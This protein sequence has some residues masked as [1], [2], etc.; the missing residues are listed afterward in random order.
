M[1][2]DA[3]TQSEPQGIEWGPP[4]WLPVARIEDDRSGF[5][6]GER[7]TPRHLD[8][9]VETF[10]PRVRRVRVLCGAHR[11]MPGHWAESYPPVGEVVEMDHD[12]LNLWFRV[13]P[14][15]DP[16]L[17]VSRIG[18]MIA[19]G[20][21]QM[22]IAYLSEDDEVEG[23]ARIW[24]LAMLSGGEPPGIPNMPSWA[25]AGFGLSDDELRAAMDRRDR[26]SPGVSLLDIVRVGDFIP[27]VSTNR[28]DAL[29]WRAA[30][31]RS[32]VTEDL[33]EDDQM[34]DEDIRKMTEG[35]VS[36]LGPVLES[37]RAAPEPEPEPAVEPEPVTTAAEDEDDGAEAGA[38]RRATEELARRCVVAARQATMARAM[39]AED[40]NEQARQAIDGGPAAM[41]AFI[42]T[43]DSAVR[44]RSGDLSQTMRASEGVEPVT[45]NPGGR[46]W[47]VWGKPEISADAERLA[48]LEAVRRQH[49]DDITAQMRAAEQHLR[50]AGAMGGAA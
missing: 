11:G 47:Q 29:R 45:I 19:E 39:R 41:R 18:A 16:L 17:R 27:R 40:A 48:I 42:A 31:T 8:E 20:V 15:I 21:D 44:A 6:E 10:D 22:S 34:T 28:A 35:V 12:G 50:A 32:N 36:A 46:Q 33:L 25:D 30:P 4:R 43:V 38:E 23:R 5:P 9:Y 26:R 49:P 24:H 1:P 3:S 14:L 7:I 2:D 37:L 13:R